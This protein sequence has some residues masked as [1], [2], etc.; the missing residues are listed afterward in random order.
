MF[1]PVTLNQAHHNDNNKEKVDMDNC[2]PSKKGYLGK[3]TF[4]TGLR[5]RQAA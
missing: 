1:R 5:L 2:Q 3:Y 4:S